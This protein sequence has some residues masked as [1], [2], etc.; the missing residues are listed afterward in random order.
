MTI[1]RQFYLIIATAL[2]LVIGFAIGLT[3][4]FANLSAEGVRLMANLDRTATL[5]QEL[6]KGNR[7]QSDSLRRQLTQLDS[8]FPD[9]YRKRSYALGEQYA[10]YLK[11]DI[12][13]QERLTVESVRALQSELSILSMHLF[14]QLRMGNQAEADV[15]LNRLYQLESDTRSQLEELN[16]LQLDKLRAVVDHISRWAREGLIAVLGLVAALVLVT[17]AATFA[18]RRRILNPVRAI[19]L[20][21]NR[22]R[23]GDLAARVP[24]DRLDELGHLTQG[25]NFMAESLANSYTTLEGKVVERTAQ[26]Q[27]MQRQLIQAEK[28]SAVGLLVSGVAHEL[29]NPLS[30]IMGFA[31]LAKMEFHASGG[32]GQGIHLLEELDSQVERCRRIVA[33]L[34]QF[35]RQQE[36][37]LEAV[38][39]NAVVDQ[40]LQLREYELETRN[41]ALV[42]E[43]DPANPVLCADPSKLQQ[44]VLNLL[45]NAHDAI[46]ETGRPGTI[47]VRTRAESDSVVLDFRDDGPGFLDA[48][49]ACDPFYST[50]EVGK[51]TG[52]GL[53]VCYG[54][55][56]EHHGDLVARN[57]DRGAE[58]IVTLPVGDPSKL[59]ARAQ[60]DIEPAET[61]APPPERCALVVDDEEMLLRLQ[62]SFL[63]KLGVRTTGVTTGEDAV[64]HLQ[65]HHVDIV[66]SDVRMPGRLDG[67]QLFE[68]VRAHQPQLTHA[69]VF[70]SG[71]VVGAS[72]G[73]LAAETGVQRIAKPFRFEEYARVVRQV[74]TAGG[75][76]P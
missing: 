11:L 68:W 41:I 7:E 31:E 29:N 54:I 67:V 45:N 28:M 52:L 18:L 16:R 9:Q 20:A 50:K 27:A 4:Q 72:L 60:P 19:L 62:T 35:A 2:L 61:Q 69:F 32:H 1:A 33:N 59:E 23:G 73:D 48:E 12:A 37:H 40:V 74:L 76:L 39:I 66:I 49:R 24:V 15:R 36:P 13:G 43:F 51:G 71:D 56:R 46:R 63:A 42:R 64:H 6:V 75:P 65:H 53:S 30:A 14:E 5:N 22:I 57:W 47:W 26:I 21:S 34:L 44:V 70:V 3:Y 25:F 55:V 38:A 17:G 10:E 8:T 58:V